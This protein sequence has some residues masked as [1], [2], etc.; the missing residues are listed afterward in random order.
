MLDLVLLILEV[1][2]ELGSLSPHS[3][4]LF[5][6]FQIRFLHV[7]DLMRLCLCQLEFKVGLHPV[8]KL[9]DISFLLSVDLQ[10]DFAQSFIRLTNLVFICA[11]TRSIFD[12]IEHVGS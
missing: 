9:C 4:H 10:I 6:P 7:Y 3:I 5:L 11:N 12:F 8:L 1:G 2:G